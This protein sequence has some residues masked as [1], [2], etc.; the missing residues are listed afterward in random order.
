MCF[1]RKFPLFIFLRFAIAVHVLQGVPGRGSPR[2]VAS[3]RERFDDLD[4]KMCFHHRLLLS[5]SGL[6]VWLLRP[7]PPRGAQAMWPA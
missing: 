3:L 7:G 4:N 6:Y 1:Y 5:R 2:H